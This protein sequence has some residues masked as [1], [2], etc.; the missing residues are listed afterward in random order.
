MYSCGMWHWAA[1][2]VDADVSDKRIASI[3]KEE[4]WKFGNRISHIYNIQDGGHGPKGEQRQ[5]PSMSWRGG[6]MSH[7]GVLS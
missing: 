7:V 4:A 3:F 1:L 5:E 6:Y 2:W